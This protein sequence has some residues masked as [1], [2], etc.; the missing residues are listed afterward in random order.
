MHVHIA[1]NALPEGD[2]SQLP[3]GPTF[4]QREAN[5]VRAVVEVT[6]LDGSV[7]RSVIET[8]N[9]YSYAPLAAVEAARRVL[10]GERQ[11]GFASPAR[12]FEEGF[13]LS[14]A[15]TVITDLQE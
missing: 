4:E 2:L 14:I 15:G 1:G 9:S 11:P 13:N 6:G 5:W 12:V 8:V 3:D 7:A 10:K